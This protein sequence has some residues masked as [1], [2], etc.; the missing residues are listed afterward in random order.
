MRWCFACYYEINWNGLPLIILPKLMYTKDSP[1]RNAVLYLCHMGFV[2]PRWEISD[3]HFL[4]PSILMGEMNMIAWPQCA[5]SLK[6]QRKTWT[7]CLN[8]LEP[9]S[10]EQYTHEIT[11]LTHCKQCTLGDFTSVMSILS[12]QIKTRGKL[13]QRHYIYDSRVFHII[14]FLI[15]FEWF[16]LTSHFFVLLL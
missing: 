8:W 6:N 15:Y 3:R 1:L 7:N 4:N 5:L 9:V 2:M 14:F 10:P 16:V 13:R 12:K 11:D